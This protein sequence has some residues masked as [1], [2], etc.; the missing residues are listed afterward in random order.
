MG[1][2]KS[3]LKIISV[4]LPDGIT[5]DID[6]LIDLG[7]YTTR[8]EFIR[9]AVREQLKKERWYSEQMVPAE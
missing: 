3:Y 6:K 7:V 5:K 1:D 4:K 9:R 2:I 8:S